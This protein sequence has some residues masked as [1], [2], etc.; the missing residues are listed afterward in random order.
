MRYTSNLT[1]VCWHLPD[2]GGRLCITCIY[3]HIK[4]GF[5]TV[6]RVK[7]WSD[8]SQCRKQDVVWDE[9]STS[10]EL[11]VRRSTL[12]AATASKV[13]IGTV[14]LIYRCGTSASPV[15]QNNNWQHMRVMIITE[16][17]LDQ[18]VIFKSPQTNAR[19]PR[20]FGLFGSSF[21]APTSPRSST[22]ARP[23]S[24]VTGARS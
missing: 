17:K 22:H 4:P 3:P 24:V 19:W 1:V 8:R 6:F 12:T 9:V 10:D 13:M 5:S 16:S 15:H 11:T 21:P 20:L 18:S 23:A 7:H 2:C 14:P